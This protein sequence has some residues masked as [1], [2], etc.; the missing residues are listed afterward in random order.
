[1]VGLNKWSKQDVF[2]QL[3]KQVILK[4]ILKRKSGWINPNR[5]QEKMIHNEGRRDGQA[6]EDV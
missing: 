3:L 5:G 4:L 2:S 1:M 6:R